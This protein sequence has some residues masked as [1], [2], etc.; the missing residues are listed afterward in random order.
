MTLHKC[1]KNHDHVILFRVFPTGQMGESPPPPPPPPQKQESPTNTSPAPTSTRHPQAPT[2]NKVVNLNLKSKT[3]GKQKLNFS[4]C[5]LFHIKTRA[6]LKYPV[7]H[8]RL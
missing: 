1:T 8:C 6:G 4:R 5:A 3:L 2:A 7:S